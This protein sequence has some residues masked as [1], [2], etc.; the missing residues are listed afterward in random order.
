MELEVKYSEEKGVYQLYKEG[1]A[2][3]IYETKIEEHM[4]DVVKA[5]KE[6]G[7][8]TIPTYYAVYNHELEDYDTHWEYGGMDKEKVKSEYIEN[9]IYN[10]ADEMIEYLEA[11]TVS[12]PYSADEEI[13]RALDKDDFI[14]IWSEY[15]GGIS[16]VEVVNGK[17]Q[18]E[19]K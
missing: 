16:I 12:S 7:E 10:H 6:K 2:Q 8:L 18:F 14:E 11:I 17:P 1:E 19:D 4:D 3:P 9:I 13:L 15:C 5:T